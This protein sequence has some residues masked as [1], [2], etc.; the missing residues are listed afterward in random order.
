ME[1]TTEKKLF[2]RTKREEEMNVYCNYEMHINAQPE[3][4]KEEK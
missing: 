1:I 2:V 3:K 4:P